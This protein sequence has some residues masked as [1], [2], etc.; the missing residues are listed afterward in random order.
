MSGSNAAKVALDLVR[1]TQ[2]DHR[3]RSPR[4]KWSEEIRQV[5]DPFLPCLNSNATKWPNSNVPNLFFFAYIQFI[6]NQFGIKENNFFL[7]QNANSVS[8]L[9][10]GK[11]YLNR[12]YNKRLHRVWCG[13]GRR[14]MSALADARTTLHPGFGAD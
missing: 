4:L 9:I 10:I 6:R 8:H 2:A 13:T 3:G 11:I 14:M 12:V 1:E 5:T 7:A